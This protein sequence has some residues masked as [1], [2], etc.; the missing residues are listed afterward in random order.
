MAD[1]FVHESSYVDDGAEVG[2]G[3]KIWHFCHVMAGARIGGDGRLAVP[4]Q[5]DPD[6]RLSIWPWGAPRFVQRMSHKTASPD[7]SQGSVVEPF[8]S[9][10]D[11]N[12]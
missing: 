3:T 5:N 4:H 6:R 8:P 9:E 1:V 10:S 12:I 7:G 2:A 11:T